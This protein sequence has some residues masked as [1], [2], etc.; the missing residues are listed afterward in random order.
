MR[1]F[2]I[3]GL[4]MFI[5][6]SAAAQ[7]YN[8]AA[9][10][11]IGSGIGVSL[12]Q[13]IWNNYTAE[14]IL[15]K[16][17]LRDE[18]YMSALF[19]K[20]LKLLSKGLNFYIGA[21]PHLMQSKMNGVDE[22]TGQPATVTMNAYGL[23]GIGGLEMRLRRKVFSVDYIPSI[24]FNA[25]AQGVFNGRTGISARYILVTSRLKHKDQNWKFWKKWSFSPHGQD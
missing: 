23:S 22:K 15:Q 17:M 3:A 20:H 16:S 21:G 13:R 6:C 18:S 25:G 2:F 5:Y 10:L 19:E 14:L 1:I 8:T 4:L 9:G 24:D 12:Q 11:R 7:K